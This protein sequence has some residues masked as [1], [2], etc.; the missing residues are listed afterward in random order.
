MNRSAQYPRPYLISNENVRLRLEL[1]SLLPELRAAREV[2]AKL[3]TCG[4]ALGYFLEMQ[5]VES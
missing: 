1:Q 3:G 2:L 4:C 5:A